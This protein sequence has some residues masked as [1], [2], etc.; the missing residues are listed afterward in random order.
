MKS[1]TE[2]RAKLAGLAKRGLND[3]NYVQAA[4]NGSISGPIPEVADSD[5]EEA[6]SSAQIS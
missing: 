3:R 4:V 2:E 1:I 5:P 6:R